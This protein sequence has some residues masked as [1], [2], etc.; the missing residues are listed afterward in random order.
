MSAE[1]RQKEIAVIGGGII[2]ISSAVH[3]LRQGQSVTLI[4]EAGKVSGASGRSLSWL[5]SAADRT[6]EYHA[7]RITG[8]DRYR[9][10]YAQNEASHAWLRFDGGLFGAVKRQNRPPSPATPVSAPA[11]MRPSLPAA[12]RS[13]PLMNRSPAA[14]FLRRHCI[15]LVKVG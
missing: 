3:L 5:N 14:P 9:T 12:Q 2:G 13:T 4:T 6:L 10:L 15:T 1:N 11:A 7:L 8:I